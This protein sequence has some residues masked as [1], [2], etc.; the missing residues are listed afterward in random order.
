MLP[1]DHQQIFLS[2]LRDL[3]MWYFSLVSSDAIIITVSTNF[4][5]LFSK[6]QVKVVIIPT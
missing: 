3:A 1:A 4:I 2:L 6:S 5:F